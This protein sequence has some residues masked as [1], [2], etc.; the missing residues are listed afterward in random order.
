MP[1]RGAHT[2]N[3]SNVRKRCTARKQCTALTHLR[4]G[5]TAVVDDTRA[6]AVHLCDGCFCDDFLRLLKLH[7]QRVSNRCTIHGGAPESELQDPCS[8]RCLSVRASWRQLRPTQGDVRVQRV[9]ACAL[10]SHKTSEHAN[11]DPS[12]SP[13]RAR[14]GALR[15]Q[16]GCTCAVTP[17]VI[18]R[19]GIQSHAVQGSL[20]LDVC[21]RPNLCTPV[22]RAH[23]LKARAAGLCAHRTLG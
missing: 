8:S 18:T 14:A 5:R 17:N 22:A 23:A 4:E 20:Q 21:A 12:P 2:Y 10:R 9:N 13:L 19:E 15:G 7:H 6:R 11:A 16:G 3:P 1:G